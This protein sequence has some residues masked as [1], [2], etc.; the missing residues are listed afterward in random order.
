VIKTKKTGLAGH[1]ARKEGIQK[2]IK[3]RSYKDTA[4]KSVSGT[5][6]TVA[7]FRPLELCNIALHSKEML[8]NAPFRCVVSGRM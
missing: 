7:S 2:R 5:T 4:V 8:Q 6:A 3:I 1:V